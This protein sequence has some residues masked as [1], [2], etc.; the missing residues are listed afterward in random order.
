MPK[1]IEVTMPDGSVWAVPAIVV[2]EARAR[3]YATR[4]TSASTGEAFD[5]AYGREIEIALRQHDDLIDWAENNMN[6]SD[7]ESAA[8]QVKG[9]PGVDY[10]E[11]W[12]NGEKRVTTE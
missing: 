10:Q 3:Y 8:T 6:W 5:H 4:D 1:R 2:A 7:V 12:V 9:P 11:G